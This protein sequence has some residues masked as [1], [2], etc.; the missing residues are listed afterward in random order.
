MLSDE[1]LEFFLNDDIV[2]PVAASQKTVPEPIDTLK[3]VFDTNTHSQ[4]SNIDSIPYNYSATEP[5]YEAYNSAANADLND[6][7]HL[8]SP[9]TKSTT[10]KEVSKYTIK[11]TLFD[12]S[13]SDVDVVDLMSG[14]S[15]PSLSHSSSLPVAWTRTSF[16]DYRAKAGLNN[17]SKKRYLPS[18]D[19]KN[20]SSNLPLLKNRTIARINESSPVDS[21][22]KPGYS[23][24]PNPKYPTVIDL[25]DDFDM[26]S[27]KSNLNKQSFAQSN[28]FSFKL[29]DEKLLLK[30]NQINVCLHKLATG[31]IEAWQPDDTPKEIRPHVIELSGI[32]KL[33][34]PI[35]PFIGTWSSNSNSCSVENWQML[36]NTM[37]GIYSWIDESDALDN[38]FEND[39][40][41]PKLRVLQ[42]INIE[43]FNFMVSESQ[44]KTLDDY[45]IEYTHHIKDLIKWYKLKCDKTQPS[46]I[47]KVHG[48]RTPANCSALANQI[49][50]IP[51]KIDSK[52]FVIDQ[53]SPTN[54]HRLEAFNQRLRDFIEFSN[55]ESLTA[56]ISLLPKPFYVG[57]LCEE[58]QLPYYYQN[59]TFHIFKTKEST[60]PTHWQSLVNKVLGI[61]T[62]QSSTTNR[63]RSSKPQVRRILG[64]SESAQNWSE[65]FPN[66]KEC[67]RPLNAYNADI[68]NFIAKDLRSTQKTIYPSKSLLDFMIALA[69]RYSLDVNNKRN[70]VTISKSSSTFIPMNWNQLVPEVV[71]EVEEAIDE[72][73]TDTLTHFKVV[74]KHIKNRSKPNTKGVERSVSRKRKADDNNDDF[75]EIPSI[76]GEYHSSSA[77][78]DKRTSVVG[79][80]APPLR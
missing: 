20:A 3:K 63:K 67:Y 79:E 5:R 45:E 25:T 58:Y 2:S 51:G 9:N 11:D 13:D 16:I 26:D 12:E 54:I 49:L 68:Y 6:N 74:S 62:Q 7:I 73:T 15:R 71:K 42:Q 38:L 29:T 18:N 30:L 24:A 55:K 28:S 19:P 80:Y 75:L 77:S 34:H 35:D 60:A 1:E 36:P 23:N 41:S 27:D 32:Y 64:A 43:I 57:M 8:I 44:E 46:I 40:F 61:T 21:S 47:K 53:F 70:K 17:S 72:F 10:D 65:K 59:Q 78:S 22:S 37:C 66:L 52:Y 50:N 33:S 31:M 69:K 48:S 14:I 4:T 39:I 56:D 76:R